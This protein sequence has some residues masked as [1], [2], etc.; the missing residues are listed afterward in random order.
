MDPVLAALLATSFGFGGAGAAAWRRVT[1]RWKTLDDQRLVN[2]QAAAAH[3]VQ[4]REA[5]ETLGRRLSSMEALLEDARSVLPDL[6]GAIM[7]H[8]LLNEDDV[9]AV[10]LWRTLDRL[11]VGL[12]STPETM[13][14]A[15]DPMKRSTLQHLFAR[16]TADALPVEGQLSSASLTQLAEAALLM[17]HDATAEHLLQHALADRPGD[18]A[19]HAI[20]ERIAARRGDGAARLAHLE[21]QLSER[22]DDTELLRR[23]AHLLASAGR[24]RGRTTR[25]PA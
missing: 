24:S 2:E 3:A 23:Q 8:R 12:P 22:P 17:G 20:A 16:A 18:A 21:A 25:S 1:M 6:D 5:I 19:L 13:E 11:V 4:Q 9:D 15:I 14:A 7:A 10:A